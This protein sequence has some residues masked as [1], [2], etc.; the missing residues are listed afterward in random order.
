VSS[1]GV[2]TI[3]DASDVLDC[4]GLAVSLEA[5]AEGWRRLSN[6]TGEEGFESCFA[7]CAGFTVRDFFE[8]VEGFVVSSH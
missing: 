5:A 4:T 7:F 8:E 1:K 6:I 2:A 3:E